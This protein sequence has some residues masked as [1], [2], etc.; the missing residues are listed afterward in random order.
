MILKKSFLLV[1]LIFG[2]TGCQKSEIDKCVEAGMRKVEA[3]L[4]NSK[5][6]LTPGSLDA[7]EAGWRLAC[8]EAQGGKKE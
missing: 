5:A 3:D 7:A 6:Q 1:L 8:L 4:A 2:L